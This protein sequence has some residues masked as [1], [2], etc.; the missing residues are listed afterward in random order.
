MV[1]AHRDIAGRSAHHLVRIRGAR[2]RQSRELAHLRLV[3]VA[4]STLDVSTLSRLERKETGLLP[5]WLVTTLLRR[6]GA[7][8]DCPVRPGAWA[9][10]ILAQATSSLVRGQFSSMLRTLL[11]RDL[12]VVQMDGRT[13]IT[14]QVFQE[15]ARWQVEGDWR[16]PVM[17][18]LKERAR[19]DRAMVAWL[20]AGVF[21][22]VAHEETGDL[23]RALRAYSLAARATAA[24]SRCLPRACAIADQARVLALTGRAAEGRALLT[25]TQR[26][27]ANAPPFGRTRWL[28]AE[29]L[30]HALLGETEKAVEALRRSAATA[31]EIPNP[32]LAAEAESA[33]S[34]VCRSRGEFDK[35]DAAAARA[36]ALYFQVGRREKAARMLEGT[37]VPHTFAETSAYAAHGVRLRVDAFTP[38]AQRPG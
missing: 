25:R 8:L 10:I 22:G 20:W 7:P 34:S 28:H 18:C 15:Y 21:E 24:V 3:D 6:L 14:A 27:V 4:G 30:V 13:E 17:C 31:L 19:A 37:L 29:G 35:A 16:P 5:V 38:A 12:L 2:L 36:A 11:L 33:M 32:F 26:L 23:D 9:R 1:R